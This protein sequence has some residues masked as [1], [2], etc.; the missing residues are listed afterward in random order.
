[1]GVLFDNPSKWA[2]SEQPFLGEG[3]DKD[4]R[5]HHTVRDAFVR[6]AFDAGLQGGTVHAAQLREMT[7]A[8]AVARFPVLVAAAFTIASDDDLVWLRDY[9]AAGG[10]LVVGIRTG[11]EDEEARARLETKPAFLDEA[12]GTWYDEFSNLSAPLPVTGSGL[13]LPAGAAT[14]LWADGLQATDAD[15]LVGYDHPHFGRWPAVTTNPHGSGRVTVVGTVPN[16]ELSAALMD[17]AVDVSR[18]TP[19]WRPQDETQSVS[20]STN[21]RGETIHVLHNWSWN[22]S[23]YRLPDAATDVLTGESLTAGSSI[24]LGSWDVRVL[25]S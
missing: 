21:Q 23:S 12:A 8:E 17:W 20:N 19:G 15:V 7:A 24:E 16:T 4:V 1:V 9:A 25:A 3:M 13:E 22:A 6:G 18:G 11:Y 2:Q 14:T 10:H 5:T